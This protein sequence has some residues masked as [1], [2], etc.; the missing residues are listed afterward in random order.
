MSS[1]QLV[2]QHVEPDRVGIVTAL[3]G[4]P[5][6]PGEI[7]GDQVGLEQRL[8]G[9]HSVAVAANGVDLAVVRDEPER[10]RPRPG[11]ERVG[12]EPGVH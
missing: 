6:E 9:P 10:V 11:R 1:E 8:A 3:D 2:L 12:G 7:A 5:I 4:R